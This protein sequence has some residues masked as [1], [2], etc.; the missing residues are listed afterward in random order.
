MR[1]PSRD[2]YRVPVHMRIR[3]RN[4]HVLAF[5]YGDFGSTAQTTL[6]DLPFAT[7]AAVSNCAPWHNA[8]TGLRGLRQVPTGYAKS[9]A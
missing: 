6:I 2:C 9:G 5:R 7:T 8:A 4:A 3:H 1:R